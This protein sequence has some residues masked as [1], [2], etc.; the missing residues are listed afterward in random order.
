MLEHA[1]DVFGFVPASCVQQIKDVLEASAEQFRTAFTSLVKK[2]EASEA[3]KPPESRS[4]ARAAC[5][6]QAEANAVW[7]QLQTTLPAAANLS[8]ADFICCDAFHMGIQGGSVTASSEQF[9]TASVRCVTAGTRSVVCVPYSAAVNTLGVCEPAAL[10]S[11]LLAATETQLHALAGQQKLFAVTH[12]VG[13]VLYLPQGWLFAEKVTNMDCLGYLS[14]G[15][16]LND[17]EG[18]TEIGMVEKIL[19]ATAAAASVKEHETIDKIAQLL[20]A[21]IRR[22]RA[23][24]GS[25]TPG[26]GAGDAPK[27]E[28][29]PE[30]QRKGGKGKGE[31]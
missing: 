26:A 31:Q 13:E 15:L 18:V 20:S 24:L 9:F 5:K 14:R 6:M 23:V 11:S 12:G 19:P 4:K 16:V 8:T 27:D 29:S 25:A 3:A 10:W 17:F 1:F 7:K 28:D 30:N 21:E 2:H 22:Q